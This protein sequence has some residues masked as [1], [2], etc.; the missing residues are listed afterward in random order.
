[1]FAIRSQAYLLVLLFSISSALLANIRL[2]C[3]GLLGTTTGL[4][5][6]NVFK[7]DVF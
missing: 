7:E 1:M 4:I 5:A 6:H 2:S 3:K